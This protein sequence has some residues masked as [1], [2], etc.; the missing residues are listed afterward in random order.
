VPHEMIV[1]RN[2]IKQNLTIKTI[3]IPMKLVG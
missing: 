3:Y 2:M 1:K